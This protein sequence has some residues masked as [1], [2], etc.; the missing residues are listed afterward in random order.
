MATRQSVD[1]LLQQCE[2][3]LRYAQSQLS[4]GMKQEHYNDT[5]YTKAQLGLENAYKELEELAHSANDQ[6]REQLY[7]MRLQ[8]QQTQN[9]MILTEH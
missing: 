2:D 6:Q 3:A 8:I 1:K 5:E 9:Q 7:R 4:E